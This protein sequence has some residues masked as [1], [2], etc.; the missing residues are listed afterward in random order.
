MTM[1]WP[2]FTSS[3]AEVCVAWVGPGG[4]IPVM[5]FSP[6]LVQKL[7]EPLTKPLHSQSSVV[8]QVTTIKLFVAQSIFCFYSNVY[9]TSLVAPFQSHKPDPRACETSLIPSPQW[10]LLLLMVRITLHVMQTMIPL[11]EDWKRDY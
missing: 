8:L 10:H 2:I 7:V 4:R 1:L 11:V 9:R 5:L 6:D 3:Q